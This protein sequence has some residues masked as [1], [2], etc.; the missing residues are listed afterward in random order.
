MVL[1]NGP[2]QFRRNNFVNLI[3]GEREGDTATNE[4]RQ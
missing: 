1:A 3:V 4:I 2:N